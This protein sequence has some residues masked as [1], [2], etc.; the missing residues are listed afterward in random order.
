MKESFYFILNGGESVGKGTQKEMLVNL[1]DDAVQIR[2]PGGTLEAEIIRSVILE[3]DVALK[4]RLLKVQSLI[5]NG[6]V[7]NLCKDYL[8]LAKKEMVMHGLNGKAEAYLYAASRAESNKKVVIPAIAEGKVILGDRSVAC[9]MAYQGHARGLGME[10][11]WGINQPAIEKAHPDLEI[12]L[13]LPLEESLKRLKGRVEKQ[14]R[15]D[16]ESKSFHKRVRDGYLEYYEKYCPYPYVIVD[17]GGTKEEVHKRIKKIIDN[18][19][20]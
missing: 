19:S 18:Y 7:I 8:T 2:E 15:M 9:S 17:A 3:K 20:K 11:I 14:D 10:M 12:F 4:E 5:D 1:Y 13:N 16:L 6:D